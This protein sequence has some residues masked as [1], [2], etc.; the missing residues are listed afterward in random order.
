M[1]KLWD[2][3]KMYDVSPEELKA[4]KERAKMRQTLKAE[5]IKK[6]TNPFASPESG[7]FLFDPAVQRFISLKATQ[8]ERFKGSF[9][10]IVAA[11]GLFIVPVG[12]L[13]YA[14]IKNRDEKEK[15]YR[16]GEVMYKDRK[17]KFF[18]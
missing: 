3:W 11:V 15:M 1:P 5:W 18:Y 12:V 13:C 10:S 14:A 8:A 17:D 6:S 7:G 2:P 16:N 4:I 9:K